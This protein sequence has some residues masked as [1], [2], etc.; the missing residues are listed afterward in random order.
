M[1]L[2]AIAVLAVA[3]SAGTGWAQKAGDLGAGV[4]LGNPTGGSAKYWLSGTQALDAGLGFSG[5]F[6]VHADYLWHAWDVLPKPRQGRLPAYLGLGGRVEA[7]DDA[8]FGIRTV[9]GLAYWLPRHPIEIFLEVVPVFRLAPS[10][11]VDL[12]AGIGLRYYFTKPR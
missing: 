6:A 8:Q 9:G 3:L 11:G 10:T 7:G 5:D 12:D 2:L 4:I 1:R